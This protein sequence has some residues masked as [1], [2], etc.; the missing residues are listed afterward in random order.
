LLLAA[1]PQAWVL[2]ARRLSQ[3]ARRRGE[4]ELAAEDAFA[5]EARGDLQGSI[6]LWRKLC[7]RAPEYALAFAGL[8]GALR[9]LRQLDAARAVLEDAAARLAENLQVSIE[10]GWLALDRNEPDEALILWREV[11]EQHSN[12]PE[13]YV[14]AAATLRHLLRFADADRMLETAQQRFPDK[15]FIAAH[16]AA[17]ADMAG[18][19]EEALRRWAGVRTRFPDEPIAYAGLGAALKTVRR[20]DEADAILADGMRLFP[21]NSNVAINHALVAGARG[22]WVEAM[23]RW[24]A[25]DA[26]F[27]QD[28]RVREGLADARL[29]QQFA[30][31]DAGA[32]PPPV[33]SFSAAVDAVAGATR[34][35]TA[36]ESLGENCEL[37]FVQ[38]H[39]GA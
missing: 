4:L 24:Q 21:T 8:G 30:E 29:H 31:V 5:A 36:F 27:P 14:G 15:A 7:D 39:F 12:A 11:R 22:D 28:L 18:N 20:F 13:G 25:L 38:R 6:E 9:K 32:P 19:L 17:N 2:R 33:P 10:R 23:R 37:G 35:L 34:L 3:I 26:R 1:V 16:Y